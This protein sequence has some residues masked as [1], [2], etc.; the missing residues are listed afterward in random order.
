MNQVLE[1]PF[2][3]VGVKKDSL[4]ST[5]VENVEGLSEEDKGGLPDEVVEFWNLLFADEAGTTKAPVEE[6]EKEKEEQPEK[7]TEEKTEEKTEK[8]TTD[9]PPK[10][11]RRGP[12]PYS[13]FEEL[14][15]WL[16]EQN[17]PTSAMDKLVLEGGTMAAI[18]EKFKPIA[19][20]KSHK[21]FKNAGSLKAHI[22]YRES[23]GWVYDYQGEGDDQVVKLIGFER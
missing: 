3:I 6:K 11:K 4:L 18:L 12:T 9:E 16:N 10:K 17:T 7:K 15:A 22:K 2:K 13:N 23:K 19:E 21:G 14:V 8:E 1:S 5:F 20:E